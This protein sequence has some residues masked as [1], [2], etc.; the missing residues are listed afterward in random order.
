MT[1][2]F[3]GEG[4][5]FAA[6]AIKPGTKFDTPFENNCVVAENPDT[7][8]TVAGNQFMF[9]AYDSENVLCRY[10]SRMVS[11]IHS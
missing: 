11:W 5:E 7:E 4:I 6:D 2:L 1:K 8:E 9:D 3:Q 10:N